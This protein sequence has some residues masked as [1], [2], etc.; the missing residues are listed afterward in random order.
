MSGSQ[1]APNINA[2]L[3][4][5]FPRAMDATEQLF[6]AAEPPLANRLARLSDDLSRRNGALTLV[7]GLRTM[8]ATPGLAA[9]EALR[10]DYG[11][12][13]EDPRVQLIGEGALALYF[14]LRI[15]D[16]LVDEP[17]RFDRANVFV[18]EIFR[19]AGERAFAT[20]LDGDSNFFAYYAETMNAFAGAAVWEL[21]CFR[22]AVSAEI[23]L[24]RLGEKFLPMAIPL[25]A[26]ALLARRTSQLAS[27]AEYVTQ[28]GTGL[29]MVNDIL[30]VR[31][32]HMRRRLTPVLK[33]LYTD[34]NISPSESPARIRLVL[35]AGEVVTRALAIARQAF[36]AAAATALAMGAPKLAALANNREE[37]AA[38]VP[39]RLLALH[40]Q[41]NAL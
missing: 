31:E 10:E 29:Q 26:L 13:P 8:V 37:F 30:N 15:Q 6:R 17:E 2:D 12:S 40:F 36:Q 23:D 5:W 28:L 35:L 4:A 19:G 33:W 34:E 38:S 32:D 16:D 18:L 11:V 39:D 3:P 14:Y 22:A 21:D 25:G 1:Q 27:I 9:M 41:V 7:D 20:A 24:R